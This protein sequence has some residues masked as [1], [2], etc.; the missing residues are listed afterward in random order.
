MPDLLLP[1]GPLHIVL[2]H[3]PIGVLIAICILELLL[4]KK[5]EKQAAI[6]LLHLLLIGSSA[7]TIALGLA[8]EEVGQYSGEIN[9]H[10]IWG[11]IFS[12]CIILTYIFHLATR[13]ISTANMRRGYVLG[14]SA[15]VAAMIATGHYGG[16]LVHG[17]GFLTKSFKDHPKQ[18][19]A[20]DAFVEEANREVIDAQE[21]VHSAGLSLQAEAKIFFAAQRVMERHCYECHGPTKQKGRY[22]LDQEATIYTPG[23]SR[24]LPIVAGNPDESEIIQRILLPEHD[25][26]IMP[27]TEK[28]RMPAADIEAIVNWVQNGADWLAQVQIESEKDS[29]D[30]ENT[31]NDALIEKVN[32]TGAKAEYNAWGDN[33]IRVDLGVVDLDQLESA[34]LAI[35]E[36]SDHISWLDCSHLDLPQSFFRQLPRYHKLERLHLDYS[37]VTDADLQIL[38]QLPNLTYLNLYK[39]ELSD[40]A[41]PFIKSCSSLKKVFLGAT[42]VTKKGAAELRAAMPD[43]ELI[44]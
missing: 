20:L 23:K 31:T 14:L 30:R 43:L 25:D 13:F 5:E 28:A 2:L 39:T 24:L 17:K 33:S 3:I 37:S 18:E 9:A 29:I 22:R 8:Y 40:A 27:P 35:A 38:E 1:F 32:L 15:S 7:V 6:G 26:A 19:L 42:K 11:F 10:K 16:E 21:V 41:I 44:Y 34:L 4:R 36:L 12:G